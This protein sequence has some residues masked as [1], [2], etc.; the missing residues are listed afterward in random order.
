MNELIFLIFLI[1]LSIWGIR[2]DYK[3]RLKR[4]REPYN[5][6]IKEHFKKQLEKIDQDERRV[7]ERAYF[8]C[9]KNK[10]KSNAVYLGKKFYRY[11]NCSTIFQQNN[12][13]LQI[14]N[15]ILSHS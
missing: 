2:R 15:D 12:I 4:N 13:Q 1:L 10:D 8:Q 9:L 3:N 11:D 14:Q 6:I 5:L 7:W